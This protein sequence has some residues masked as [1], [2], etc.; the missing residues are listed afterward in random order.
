MTIDHDEVD[1]GAIENDNVEDD[2]FES[3]TKIL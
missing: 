1:V 2:N 3:Y